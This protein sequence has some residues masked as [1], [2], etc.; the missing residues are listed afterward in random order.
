MTNA[1]LT[2]LLKTAIVT[3]KNKFTLYN[4]KWIILLKICVLM[5]G[6][7]S[8]FPCNRILNDDVSNF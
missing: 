8:S 6:Y 3:K 1:D 4:F 5:D 7:T 2:P